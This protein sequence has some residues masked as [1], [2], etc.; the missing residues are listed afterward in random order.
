[1]DW[2]V[3]QVLFWVVAGLVSF[4]FSLGNAR[5]WTSIAVGFF[6]ILVGEVIPRAL[7]FLPGAGL[8]QVQAMGYIVGTIA[9]MVMTHGFMEYYVFSRTL[10]LEGNKLHVYLGTLAVL[11][12]S[13]V[14]ILINPVPSQRTLR[15]ISV[16]QNANWV[17]L[18]LINIDM[19]RKIY[20]NV[21]D[22]PIARGFIAFM[23][24]FIFIFLWKGSELYIQVYGLDALAGRYPLRYQL[25]VVVGN[26]G[27][28]LA[29]IS[30]GG[31]FIYL[32][33][34]LR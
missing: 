33:R 21:K 24:V 29:G 26:V 19:I 34:L 22:S 17:F 11:A 7:P 28:L 2:N 20:G 9:I 32:A 1:M 3:L 13:V 27:N 31:T 6:L 10:E 14:F 25:S 12:A 16:I 30:V 23:A 18:S 15:T 4:Y 5:V 8:P